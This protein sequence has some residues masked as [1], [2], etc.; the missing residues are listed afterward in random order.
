MRRYWRSEHYHMSIINSILFSKVQCG[1]SYISHSVQKWMTFGDTAVYDI[2]LK[3]RITGVQFSINDWLKISLQLLILWFT[4]QWI[5]H[6][7]TSFMDL[8]HYSRCWK[9]GVKNFL[10]QLLIFSYDLGLYFYRISHSVMLLLF[11][12]FFLLCNCHSGPSY[13]KPFR[14]LGLLC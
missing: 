6:S 3:S 13:L 4:D 9:A 11:L 7:P 2:N 14:A 1:R 5:C 12:L 8:I 10:T